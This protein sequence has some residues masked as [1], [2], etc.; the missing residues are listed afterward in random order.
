LNGTG[1]RTTV[2]RG[3]FSKRFHQRTRRHGEN[4]KEEKDEQRPAAEEEVA[5]PE[6][7]R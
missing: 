6:E 2:L 7:A 5:L 3:T 4:R 1:T